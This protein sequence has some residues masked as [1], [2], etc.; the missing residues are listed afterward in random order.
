MPGSASDVGRWGA[1]RMARR[2]RE[3]SVCLGLLTGSNGS[4]PWT[5]EQRLDKRKGWEAGRAG[6]REG[7][8]RAAGRRKQDS[9]KRRAG[10]S[11]GSGDRGR[12][13]VDSPGRDSTRPEALAVIGDR[14]GK[15]AMLV[16]ARTVPDAP[17][18]CDTRYG[19]L[20]G[21]TCCERATE[22]LGSDWAACG[23]L[24]GASSEGAVLR[25]RLPLVT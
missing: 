19:P 6:E 18:S 24:R 15:A 13:T 17:D 1:L 3:A 10:A 9:R 21:G 23:A 12:A 8:R 11:S 25:R 2:W 16:R 4:D 5:R 14:T 20:G 7:E 22:M